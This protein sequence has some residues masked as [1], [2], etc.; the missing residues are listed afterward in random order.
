M[1]VPAV[2]MSGLACPLLF[3]YQVVAK[4]IILGLF[5]GSRGRGF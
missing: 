4:V 5:K 2:H 3:P 1:L